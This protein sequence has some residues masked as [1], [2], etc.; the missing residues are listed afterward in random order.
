MER[1]ITLNGKSALFS[2]SGKIGRNFGMCVEIDRGKPLQT[3]VREAQKA[4]GKQ[5]G[6]EW[7][8]WNSKRT[9]KKAIGTSRK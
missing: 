8:E 4:W 7:K 5:F 9:K 3:A 2:I 1:R 6:A